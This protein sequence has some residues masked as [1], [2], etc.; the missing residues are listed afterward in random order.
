MYVYNLCARIEI[1]LI[2]WAW[3]F[4]LFIQK[5]LFEFDGLDKCATADMFGCMC[6]LYMSTYLPPPPIYIDVACTTN[7]I[8]IYYLYRSLCPAGGA[9]VGSR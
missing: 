2:G 5:Y 8:M 1:F 4:N 3:L 6:L 7:K 9:R